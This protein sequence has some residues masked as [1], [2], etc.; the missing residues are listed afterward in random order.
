MRDFYA[1]NVELI[2]RSFTGSPYV[3]VT[4]SGWDSRLTYAGMM[5]LRTWVD[6]WLAEN[7]PALQ[8]ASHPGATHCNTGEIE[9]CV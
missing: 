5:A 8:D 4:G 1:K 2:S 6:E 7:G 3:E 9:G